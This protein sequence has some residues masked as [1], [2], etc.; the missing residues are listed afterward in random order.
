MDGAGIETRRNKA[1]FRDR[2]IDWICQPFGKSEALFLEAR[3]VS[4]WTPATE[5]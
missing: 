1:V 4:K 5:S 3:F 2:I